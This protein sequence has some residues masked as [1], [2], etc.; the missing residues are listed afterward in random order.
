MS[1]KS[2]ADRGRRMTQVVFEYRTGVTRRIATGALLTGSWDASGYPSTTWTSVPMTETAGPDGT[3]AFRATVAL[4]AS[5]PSTYRWGV[6]LL[7]DDGSRIWGIPGEV[8]DPTDSDQ[9][10][11]LTLDPAGPATIDVT[12]GLTSH[13]FL[14]AVPD[15][16]GGILFRV[17]APNAR[18]VEVAFGGPS[19]YIADDGYGEATAQARLPLNPGP[20]GIWTAG[21]DG[22]ADHLGGYYLYRVTREDGSVA[23]RTDPY[24]RQQSGGGDVNPDGAHY[25]GDIAGLDGTVSCSVVVDASPAAAFGTGAVDFWAD[26]LDP[27]HPLP[28][29]VEDLVIYELH[30]GALGFGEAAETEDPSGDPKAG[31]FADAVAFVDYLADLGVNAVELLPILE[32][33]GSRSWGYGTSHFLAVE[34]SAGGRAGLATFVRACHRRGIAVLVDLVF[35]H[36]TQDAERAEW[37]YDTTTPSHNSYYWYEGSDADH[38]AFPDGGY[39]DNLSSGW[40]PRYHE[41]QVRAL[42]VAGAAALIEE[43]HVDGFRLDQTTSIHLYNALHADGS[44]V[45]AANV[46]GRK[47]LRELCQ[48]LRTMAPDVIL[49]AEDHSGWDQVTEP[50]QTGGLGFDARWYVDFYHHLIGDKDEG[51]EYARL[52]DTAGR[53]LEGPLA[54]GLFA[55]ALA[56]SANRTVVYPESHDEAGNAEHSERN[57]LIAVNNAPLVGETRWFAEARLR[58]VTALSLLAAGTP[59]FLMGDEVGAQQA[60]TYNHFTENKEDL[61][62]LRA[63]PGAGLFAAHRDL[64]GLRLASAAAKSRNLEVLH[65][66]DSG[67]VIAFRR[68]SDP[69]GDDQ[70][71]GTQAGGGPA[72]A[73]VEDMLVVCSLNN[74]PFPSYL[75]RHPA[76]SGAPWRLRLSTDD[77]TYNGR[78]DAPST[79]NFVVTPDGDGTLNLQLPAVTTLVFTRLAGIAPD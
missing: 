5:I 19:G 54:M 18:A 16:T 44:P 36:F 4:D 23:W 48:T 22:F 75:L 71:G 51:P 46:A 20:D 8:A 67:R 79:G 65:T 66:N 55:G 52:L 17:W 35:N 62:G 76:L 59:M 32:F 31:T 56:G 47:F 26:E 13:H 45:G 43:F 53:D 49:I 42:F 38:A 14:G 30:V 21:A 27:A 74:L 24:S 39:V 33:S 69:A 73:T 25:D 63:G 77:P 10:R 1:H 9:V 2:D 6:W 41:E 28:R 61:Y 64:V 78:A 15:G 34:K 3:P 50:A 70:T 58:C 68:W 37:M 7:G 40:A 29:R 72:R 60:Y 12:F 11:L 57:I